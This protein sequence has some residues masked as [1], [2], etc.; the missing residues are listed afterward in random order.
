VRRQQTIPSFIS[1]QIRLFFGE[2]NS[3]LYLMYEEAGRSR[4]RR[5][6]KTFLNIKGEYRLQVCG[7]GGEKSP[8]LSN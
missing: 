1:R 7:G 6:K 8:G 5:R 2:N 4:R 3:S